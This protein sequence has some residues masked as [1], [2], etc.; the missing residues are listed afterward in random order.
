AGK[1][2][3]GNAPRWDAVGAIYGSRV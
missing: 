3:T 2:V 1:A